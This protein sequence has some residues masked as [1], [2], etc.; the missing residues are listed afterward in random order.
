MSLKLLKAGTS[1]DYTDAIA[2]EQGVQ[3]TLPWVQAMINEGHG[4]MMYV[5]SA[6][7][8]ATLDASWANTDPD[9]SLDVPDGRIVI[10]IR[11]FL[12]MEVYG[13]NALFETMVL[14]SR[15]L[16][17][18]SAGTVFSPI[19]LRTRTSGGS[20]C[21]AYTGP[22]VTSGYTTGAFELY[23][24][25]QTKAVTLG[26]ADDDSHFENNV[27]EWNIGTAGWGPVLEGPA[28]I[29]A[30]ATAQAAAGY[31]QLYWLE[32]AEGEI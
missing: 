3:F 32:F 22:T 23:R 26:T 29:A 11:Y 12:H 9:I 18:S 19:P 14:C 13:T 25:G 10:P 20:N 16:A 31:M 7:T 17:A 5:G 2:N 15:T 30:W 6:S 27:C 24:N 28:S 8:A 4:Y 21:S 1:G